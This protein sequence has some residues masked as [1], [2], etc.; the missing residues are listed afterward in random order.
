MTAAGASLHISSMASWSP[1]QSEPLTVSYMCQRQSSG[2]MFPSAA[3]M[4]PCA[5]T[6]WLRVGKSL[7]MHAVDRPA[8]A[9]PRGARAQAGAAGAHDDDIVR[10]VNEL[11]GTQSG[12]PKAMRSTAKTPSAAS[13]AWTKPD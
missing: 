11:I 10:V 2:P 13:A 1:N 7:L 12:L 8:S 6:V 9:R 5:A 4:P 3:L